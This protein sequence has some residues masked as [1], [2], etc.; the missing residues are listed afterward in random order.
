MKTN[1]VAAIFSQSWK[2][3]HK[4]ENK[5]VCHLYVPQFSYVL[6]SYKFILYD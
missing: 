2:N 6:Y 3:S 4:C 1:F 5:K